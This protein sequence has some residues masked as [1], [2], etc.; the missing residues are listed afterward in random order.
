MGSVKEKIE[1]IEEQENQEGLPGGEGKRGKTIVRT[2][3]IGILANIF[4]A[5]FKAAVGALTHSIAIV[6]DA[7]NNR[8]SAPSLRGKNLTASIPSA[9]AAS[10]I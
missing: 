4:L 10:S 2:S 1:T 5:A 9:T 3:I 7:V 6:L 8:S